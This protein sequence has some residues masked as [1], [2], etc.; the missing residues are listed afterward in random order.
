MFLFILCSFGITFFLCFKLTSTPFVPDKEKLPQF[1][2]DLLSCLF[3]T[4]FWAGLV[5]ALLCF[6]NSWSFS[7]ESALLLLAHGFAAAT[8]SYI[9]D[10]IMVRLET[11]EQ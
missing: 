10:T 3:C 5:S 9:I 6:W 11:T 1:L 4:G 7:L 8:T 2:Q